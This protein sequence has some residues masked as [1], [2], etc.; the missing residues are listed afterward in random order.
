ITGD[1]YGVLDIQGQK[2]RIVFHI[3]ENDGSLTATMDSPDQG[4]KGIPVSDVSTE[5]SILSIFAKAIGFEY[6]GKVNE[7]FS[8]IEGTFKQT[9]QEFELNLQREAI[10][11]E[12]PKRPQEPKVPFPYY[13]KDIK[14]FNSEDEVELAGTITLPDTIGKYPAVVLITGS[15]PQN[16]NSEVFGHKLF[17][18]LADHLTRNG[19]GVLRFDD[20]G[21]GESSGNI[22]TAT[23][24]NYA[25][26]ALAGV[27]YLQTRN[28]VD[29]NNIG[30]IGMSE[31]GMI[32]PIANSLSD[33]IAF[34][35]LMAGPGIPTPELLELQTIA[36]SR[37][38]GIPEEKI[39]F[40]SSIMQGAY[41]ILNES[42]EEESIN[43]KLKNYFDGRLKELSKEE[44]EEIGDLNI[45]IERQ[46]NLL[47]S[48][49]FRYLL[50]Y[51]PEENL[52]KVKCPVLAIN[53]EKDLQVLPKE[54]LAGIEKALKKGGNT[55][56]TIKELPN[57]NH[58]FQ[59]C[60]TGNPNEYAKIEETMN[61]L[62]LETI[63]KWISGV[64]K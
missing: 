45:F 4:A 5:N 33:D 17:L 41:K 1:W 22:Q 43:K 44:L 59:K 36:I 15:G 28:D 14:F 7:T 52:T 16:R 55:N 25:L 24:E 30:L 47:T 38:S 11:V 60:E 62:A 19:I 37:A 31:G 26:D 50:K 56:Y 9:G 35:I 40:N 6:T 13:T 10:K 20:R 48:S 57:L 46:V 29:L 39:I 61:P 42:T 34:I 2:L 53:G 3:V 23:S 27:Q 12:A 32:A 64:V 49:W 8:N 51:N 54:N 21:V 18:V 63:A 58:I